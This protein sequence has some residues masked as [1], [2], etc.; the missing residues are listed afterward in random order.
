[1]TTRELPPERGAGSDMSPAASAC[2]GAEASLAAQYL[3][4]TFAPLWERFVRGEGALVAINAAIL[5]FAQPG[6]YAGLIAL[7]LSFLVLAILYSFN[8]LHDA[9]ADR[10]NP[11][12]NPL[13][14]TAFLQNQR[15]FYYYLG[16]V[17][18]GLVL[19]TYLLL[20]ARTAAAV[21]AV[22]VVNML[23]SLWAKGVPLVDILLVAAWGAAYSAVAS[24]PW[25]I[26][27]LVGVMTSVTH[28]FQMLSDRE[29]DTKNRV[30][31]TAV[32]S[33]AATTGMLAVV[34]A[35]LALGLV[36]ALGPVW[37]LTAFVPL[38]LHLASLTTTTAWWLSR[39]YFGVTLIVA[40]GGFRGSPG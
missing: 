32:F 2:A 1:M 3:Y 19:L 15:A 7:G 23:Y 35:A 10:N 8:D 12:K 4:L 40:L 26:C 18:L 9:E 29:V 31:T 28:I 11:K 14:V 13:L 37:S 39:I 5:W 22:L 20:D 17:K 21:F 16:A 33:V 27:L 6:L 36:P 34:C 38:A 25:R 30:K 24:P